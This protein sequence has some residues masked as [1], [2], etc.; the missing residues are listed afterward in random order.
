[1]QA[2]NRL[3]REELLARFYVDTSRYILDNIKL[4]FLE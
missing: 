3:R 2:L 4:S 1:M